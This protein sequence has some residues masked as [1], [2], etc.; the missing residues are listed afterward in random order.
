MEVVRLKLFRLKLVRLKSLCLG[1]VRLKSLYL[2][3]VTV[4][5]EFNVTYR[6]EWG[7]KLSPNEHD[8]FVQ[9]F[10]RLCNDGEMIDWLTGWGVLNRISIDR[11]ARTKLIMYPPL[12]L[13]PEEHVELMRQVATAYA[14]ARDEIL[15]T[16]PESEV[17]RIA[18]MHRD[19]GR[20]SI[21]REEG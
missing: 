14:I 17:K 10:V 19:P 5:R 2:K 8:R 1:V 13:T 11:H 7:C 4:A 20:L 3:E 18:T 12:N 15:E 21:T 6:I 9:P 16:L